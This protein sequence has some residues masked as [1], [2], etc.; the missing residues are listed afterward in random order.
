M[1][2]SLKFTFFLAVLNTHLF[3]QKNDLTYY[4]D[5]RPIILR[6]CVACHYSGGPAPFTL[7]SYEDVRKRSK[8]ISYVTSI[9]YMPPWKADPHFRTFRNER[10]ISKEEIEILLKWS[11]GSLKKGKS[12]G[13]KKSNNQLDSPRK[14]AD[15]EIVMKSSYKIPADNNDDFRFF[16]IPTNLKSDKYITGI[17]FVPG[18]KKRV[19]HSRIMVD[20]TNRLSDING[21]SETD[22]AVYKFQK[23]PLA[24]EFLYG[25][26]PGNFVFRFPKG[27]GK[28]IKRNSDI[29][30]NMHYAPSTINEEDQSM[31]RLYLDDLQNI[32]REVKTFILRETNI[33]NQPF[34][35]PA[36]SAPT[37]Y[38]SSGVIKEDL[39]LLTIQPHAHLLGK[40][41]RAFA[42]TSEGDLIPLIKID[43]WDFNWQTTYQFEKLIHIPK[44][45][46]ILMEGQYDN[47]AEN[48]YNPF[49]PPRNVGYGWRTVDE[50][51][52]LIIYFVDYQINDENLLLSY[53]D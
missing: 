10:I 51:M 45:S 38:M 50:M 9:G 16:H 18:N 30:L 21:L 1:S 24:D 8:F 47:T 44:G 4:K 27:F 15:L 13:K 14:K 36:E 52:N 12:P 7:E 46:V 33:S 22:T 20:T 28:K 35:I 31:V 40:S 23:Y 25:W 48:P 11:T 3:S 41:F 19:H 17:E 43:K 26:V 2:I 49:N 53:P 39:S 5:V 6:H 37:F 29:L 34:F 42:I 32:K